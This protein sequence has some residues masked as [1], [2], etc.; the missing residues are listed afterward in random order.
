M[1][2][3]I[4]CE[5]VILLCYLWELTRIR[6]YSFL[7]LWQ[8]IVFILVGIS[9]Q[10]LVTAIKLEC[11]CRNLTLHM[12]HESLDL[13]HIWYCVSENQTPLRDSFETIQGYWLQFVRFCELAKRF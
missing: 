6:L 10:V 12:V 2:S 3:V 7:N 9:S 1:S 11:V 4:L 5:T 8:L 13:R